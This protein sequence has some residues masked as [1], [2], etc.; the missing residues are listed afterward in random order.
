MWNYLHYIHYNIT[1]IDRIFSN[2]FMSFSAYI[3]HCLEFLFREK[4]KLHT[5][6]LYIMTADSRFMRSVYSLIF[7]DECVTV[8]P[9]GLYLQCRSTI[10]MENE[11][12]NL[13]MSWR[14]LAVRV[15]F[16]MTSY[17][18]TTLN[19]QKKNLWTFT[20]S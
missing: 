16:W 11:H 19:K 7:P 1:P 13:R 12:I 5:F 9:S 14:W 3:C 10:T 20:L 8:V 17:Y 2:T 15:I 4:K 18:E 6:S